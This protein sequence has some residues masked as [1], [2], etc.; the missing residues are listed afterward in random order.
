MNDPFEAHNVTH[1]SASQINNYISSPAQFLLKVSGYRDNYGIPAM[2][3]GIAVDFAICTLLEGN[4]T[5]VD[6]ID[7]ANN[8]FTD[9]EDASMQRGEPVDRAKCNKEYESL[10]KYLQVGIPHYQSLG[11]PTGTQQKIKIELEDIPV[12]I[13]GY[14]DVQYEHVLRDIKTVGRFSSK[15]QESTQRQMAIYEK[16]TGKVPILDYLYVTSKG[17]E[18]KSVASENSDYHYAVVLK[19]CKSIMKLLSTSDDIQEVASLL[20]PDFDDW[21]WSEGEKKAAKKLWRLQ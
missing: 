7:I 6:C 8:K 10:A 20:V 13:I 12:P 18:V 21:R 15:I 9:L 14:T 11:K 2:W 4:C 17:A 3:R 1:L 19:A 16:A 5:A